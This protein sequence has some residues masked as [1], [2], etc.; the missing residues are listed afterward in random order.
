VL[1]RFYGEPG[2]IFGLPIPELI[3]AGEAA[4]RMTRK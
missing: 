4:E 1:G 3:A 2:F